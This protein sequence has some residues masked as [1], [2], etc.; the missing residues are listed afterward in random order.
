[1]PDI[2]TQAEIDELLNALTNG[3]K[4]ETE[5]VDQA[6]SSAECKTY[7]FSKAF[8][9]QK[10][11][12]RT[13][14]IVFQTFGHLLANKLSAITRASCE[15]EVL[16]VEEQSFLEFNNSLPMP[17]VLAVLRLSPMRGS[18]LLEI[19]PEAAYTIISRLLGG[20][21]DSGSSKQFTEIEMA[22]LQ[23]VTKQM[24]PIFEKSWEKVLKMSAQFE[25][26]ETSS[27]FAQITGMNEASAIIT[28][29]VTIGGNSGLISLCIPHTAIEPI[30]GSLNTLLLFS[31]HSDEV[32]VRTEQITERLYHTPVTLTA[33]FE[34]STATV[35]DIYNLQVG[36][37]IRLHQTTQQPLMVKVQHIPKFYGQIGTMG[38]NYAIRV[39]DIIEGENEDER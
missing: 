19:S 34:E 9:F 35:K 11:Q 24:L 28:L 26:M 5:L 8:K 37:V 33:Y 31:S 30:A 21:A 29:N 2:L 16:S 18:V 12:M 17:V 25:R 7:D 15:C 1:L 4:Q 27:Q 10:E 20:A 38:N 3:S 14:N 23:H 22:L 36:D 39:T 6:K 32:P 13:I